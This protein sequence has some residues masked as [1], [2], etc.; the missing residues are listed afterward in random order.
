M[1][2]IGSGAVTAPFAAA[3]DADCIVVIGARPSQNHPV[4]STY[5][6]QAAK[7]GAT[8]IV[9]DPRRQELMRHAAYALQFK[10]G[11]D[12]ALLNAMLNVIVAERLYDEQYIQAHVEGFEALREKVAEFSPEAMAE[13]CGIDADTIREV[14]RVYAKSERSVIFWGMGISQHVHGTGNA[15]CLIAL[16]LTTG[17]VGRPT[18]SLGS[19]SSAK[20]RS[21][22]PPRLRTGRARR[23]CSARDSRPMTGAAA[24]CRPTSCRPTSSRTRNT[25]SC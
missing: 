2:G 11:T 6:K 5:L 23:S 17:Q 4:A 13:I 8:L 25:P 7:R 20:G 19:G 12:V 22:I 15:R 16:A 24:S 9:I 1:E 21:R 18:T 3:E 10:P 14:A